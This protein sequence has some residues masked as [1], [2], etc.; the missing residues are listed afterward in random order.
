MTA[1]S[2]ELL[3]T[4]F[5][6]EGFLVLRGALNSK[7]DLLP[8]ADAWSNLIDRLPH[9]SARHKAAFLTISIQC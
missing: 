4:E 8:L 3:K 6:E 2:Q 5:L 1:T 7:I 9:S